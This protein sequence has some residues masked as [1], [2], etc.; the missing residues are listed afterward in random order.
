MVCAGIITGGVDSCQ[1]DSGGGLV[2]QAADGSWQVVGVVATGAVACGAVAKPG[3]YTELQPYY[4][5]I[6]A[7]MKALS[8]IV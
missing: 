5:T 1:G 2:C 6:L 8:L 7:Y 3:I 4:D